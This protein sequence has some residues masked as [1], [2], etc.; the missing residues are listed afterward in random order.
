MSEEIRLDPQYKALIRATQAGLPLTPQPYRDI[1][2]L[3]DMPADEVMRRMRRMLELGVIRRIGAI[4][5]HYAIGYV[6]NGMSVWDVEDHRADDLGEQV[7]DSGLVSHCYLR[8]RQPPL[9]P[10]NLFAMIHGRS[11]DDVEAKVRQVADIL[12][13]ASRGH[14]VLYSSRILKK[15]GLRL[16]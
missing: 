14:E 3:L 5:N 12:G 7:A 13:P 6:S 16:P 2:Q 8:R 1:G 11:R 15:T 10:Y 9:W 4:P